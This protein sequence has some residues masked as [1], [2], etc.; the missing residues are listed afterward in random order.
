MQMINTVSSVLPSLAIKTDLGHYELC[1]L[2]QRHVQKQED[3][4]F[5]R[6]NILQTRLLQSIP[7]TF[8]TLSLAATDTLLHTDLLI[9]GY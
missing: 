5:S 2:K 1:C 4:N 3:L 6:M 7:F 9:L 8:S